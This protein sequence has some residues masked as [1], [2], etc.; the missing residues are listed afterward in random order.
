MLTSFPS[1]LYGE[2]CSESEVPVIAAIVASAPQSG[3]RETAKDGTVQRGVAII[4]VDSVVV[5][6]EQRGK[7]SCHSIYL[8]SAEMHNV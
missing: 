8:R 1:A 3:E 7:R 4:F 2:K 5:T 6:R